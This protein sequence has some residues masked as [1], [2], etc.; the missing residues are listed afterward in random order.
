MKDQV[1]DVPQI[2]QKEEITQ[3][4]KSSKAVL[5][6]CLAVIIALVAVISM[7]VAPLIWKD[8]GSNTTNSTS[9]DNS[10]NEEKLEN[11]ALSSGTVTTVIDGKEITYNAAYLVDG[12]EATI[13]SGTYESI[14]DDEN[15]FLVINGGKLTIKGDDIQIT[16]GGTQADGRGDDYSFYGLNSA[17]VV[18]GGDSSATI[19]GAK[20]TTEAGGANAIVATKS[21]QIIIANSSIKTSEDGSRGLHATYDGTIEA[22]GVTISTAGQSSASIATDRGE[23][24][25]LAEN[26]DLSTSGAGSPLIYSTGNI[27][28]NYSTGTTVGAQIAVVEGSNSI[29]IEDCDFSTNGHGNRNNV[30]NAGIMIYQSMS[31]DAAEGK[32][33]FSA[34]DSTLSILTNS[35]IYSTV[36]L[37]FVTNTTADINLDNTIMNYAPTAYFVS[38]RGTS[39]WG[40]SG[41]NGGKVVVT[42]TNGSVAGPVD[43]DRISSYTTE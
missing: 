26:M 42:L 22:N 41:S 43:V 23:G 9:E 29:S 28:V 34:K 12:I 35:D 20:I 21:G 6:V 33:T 40:R 5:F 8:N 31:G 1:G 15:V 19:D 17:I 4:E 32:G 11:T 2:P 7:I 39:E 27:T 16:K 36:P 24:T 3:K 38:A 18:V 25:V 14:R 13:G 30:D 10:T 37:F